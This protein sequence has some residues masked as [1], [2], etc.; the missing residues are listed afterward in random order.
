MLQE[1]QQQHQQA[2]QASI[3]KCMEWNHQTASLS[4]PGDDAAAVEGALPICPS[5]ASTVPVDC[6]L[7]RSKKILCCCLKCVGNDGDMTIACN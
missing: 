5:V 7:N 6:F 2:L 1:K 4:Q 3:N